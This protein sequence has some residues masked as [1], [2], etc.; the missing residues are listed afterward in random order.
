MAKKVKVN[1]K[2]RTL[3][4]R[5]WQGPGEVEIHSDTARLLVNTG[6]AEY[7]SAGGQGMKVEEA[8]AGKG[9]TAVA[10][11]QKKK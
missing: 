11:N 3:V 5:K 6:K 4:D 8:T 2:Q 9:E 1:L 7:V 10:K